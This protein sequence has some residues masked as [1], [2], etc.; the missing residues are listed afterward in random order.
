MRKG[1]IQVYTGEGKGKTTA[2]MGLILRA[3]GAGF[4]VCFYQFVKNGDYNEILALKK[5]NELA[6]PG[7]ITIKQFG[8]VRKVNSAF[9]EE[10]SN[11]ALA[12]FSA[13]K[14]S[15]FSGKYDLAILDE[16]NIAVHYNQI[17]QNEVLELMQSK[18]ES[19]ELVITG[20]YA[21]EEIMAAADLVT[22]M[23]NKKHYS[24]KGVPA[25]AGIEK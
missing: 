11:A 5:I 20:R 3:L 9:T 7:K 19:L 16:L 12:G 25:R 23:E 13:V 22:I 18:P 1:Y 14:E 15:L 21:R 17:G 8:T 10:D 24:K 4:N 2:S 6:F